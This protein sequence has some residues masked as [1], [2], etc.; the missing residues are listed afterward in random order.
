MAMPIPGGVGGPDGLLLLLLLL[1]LIQTGSALANVF[2]EVLDGDASLLDRGFQEVRGVVR[3]G[4]GLPQTLQ[5]LH[6]QREA[7]EGH[8]ARHRIGGPDVEEVDDHRGKNHGYARLTVSTA[9]PYVAY[10][11]T[12]AKLGV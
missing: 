6:A 8:F 10:G 9:S 11:R 7:L 1:L 12:A 4:V 5:D 2:S 3:R